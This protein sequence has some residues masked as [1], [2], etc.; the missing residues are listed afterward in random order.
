ML[1]LTDDLISN[2][3]A[4]LS[5]W[6]REGE[7]IKKDYQFNNFNEVVQAVNRIAALAEDQHHH[8][9]IL[10]HGWNKLSIIS[11]THDANGITGR[12][13]KLAAAIEKIVNP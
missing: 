1:K 9:D 4:G 7:A 11:S 8:P 10:M 6:A 5:G 13:F 2:E 3:L 12:D